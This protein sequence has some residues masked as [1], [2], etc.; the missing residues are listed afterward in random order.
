LGFSFYYQRTPPIEPQPFLDFVTY[1]RIDTL[2]LFPKNPAPFLPF[3]ISMR[4]SCFFKKRSFPPNSK[5]IFRIN[6]P[7]RFL[8]S[9]FVHA[10][11][12]IHDCILREQTP[13]VSSFRFACLKI[14]LEQQRDVQ[15]KKA[16][17]SKVCA[18]MPRA[19]F[20]FI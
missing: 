5:N 7:A 14:A 4:I 15:T 13:S 17:A 20:L 16:R 2:L 8:P 10:K 19:I 1:R 18:G 12:Q 3:P 11:C 9:G 6:F